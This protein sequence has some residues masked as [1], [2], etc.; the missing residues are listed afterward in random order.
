[1]NVDIL[2]SFST[3][4]A[5]TSATKRWP[6]SC[7]NTIVLIDMQKITNE[8]KFDITSP[9]KNHMNFDA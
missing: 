2:F 1:M 5:S 7:H 4:T 9:E 8:N 3:T 6:H